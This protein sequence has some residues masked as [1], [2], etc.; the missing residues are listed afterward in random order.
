[1]NKQTFSL[2]SLV[3]ETRSNHNE[4]EDRKHYVKIKF[5]FEKIVSWCKVRFYSHFHFISSRIRVYDYFEDRGII[6]IYIYDKCTY[7]VRFKYYTTSISLSY[8]L[9]LSPHVEKEVQIPDAAGATEEN[10]GSSGGYSRLRTAASSV[11][12]PSSGCDSGYPPQG[13]SSGDAGHG[14]ESVHDV[15]E[16]VP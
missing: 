7:I 16:R 3:P 15:A 12:R 11:D 5:D 4:M 13:G 1:M 8:T 6:Y 14:G 2:S 9:T 10:S